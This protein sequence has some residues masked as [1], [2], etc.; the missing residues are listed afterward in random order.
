VQQAPRPPSG[1]IKPDELRV[2]CDSMLLV[3]FGF[4][5]Q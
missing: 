4:L 1:P 3:L 5:S 2:V